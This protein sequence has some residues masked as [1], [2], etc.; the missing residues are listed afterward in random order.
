MYIKIAT[1]P[2]LAKGAPAWPTKE[3]KPT[4]KVVQALKAELTAPK[5]Q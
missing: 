1:V 4:A 5:A 3:R 2:A